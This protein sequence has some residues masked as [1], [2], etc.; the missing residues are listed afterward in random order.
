MEKRKVT[1]LIDGQPC[2]LFSDDSEEYLSALE[3]KANAVMKRT[4]EFS[5]SSSYTNAILS[6][7]VLTDELLRTEQ[8]FL[9]ASTE[10]KAT[11]NRS[12]HD[13]KNP[14]KDTVKDQGQSSVW[15]IL[16]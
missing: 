9:E 2:V 4:A 13:R 12:I 3:Q 1:I 7:L 11:E 6:V 15:D 10:R 16:E 14:A 5:G 8:K